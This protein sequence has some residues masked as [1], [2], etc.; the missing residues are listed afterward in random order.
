MSYPF[1]LPDGSIARRAA[2]GI[3]TELS[4][5]RNQDLVVLSA[6]DAQALADILAALASVA[7]TGPLTD[8]ELRAAAVAISAAALPLPTG[9]SSDAT[10]ASGVGLR[11]DLDG[12][13]ESGVWTLSATP[14]TVTTITLPD[15]ARIVTLRPSADIR[16]RLNADPAAAG[17]NAFAA[18]VPVEGNSRRAFILAAGTGR[19][20]RL[21]SAAVSPTV[22]VEWR[23]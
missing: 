2:D 5:Y 1:R 21:R 15:A 19:T 9:A 16:A 6:A 23:P 17:T 14:G 18:G 11:P 3:G 13:G 22:T 10:L 12:A 7:V 8:A 20:L 4:P